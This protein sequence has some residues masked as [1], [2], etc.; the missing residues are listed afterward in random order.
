[1]TCKPLLFA[2]VLRSKSFRKKPWV[3]KRLGVPLKTVSTWIYRH[4]KK[5]ALPGAI[6]IERPTLM[7]SVNKMR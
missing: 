4:S 2:K 7:S 3:A 1:M 6:V 5:V